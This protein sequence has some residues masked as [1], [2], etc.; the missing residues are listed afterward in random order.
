[1]VGETVSSRPPRI[2]AKDITVA[3]LT[4]ALS[5]ARQ[6]STTYY[7][8]LLAMPPGLQEAKV[9]FYLL[10]RGIDE[11]EDHP[12]LAA[13][14]KDTV[15]TEVACAL[16]TRNI[17]GRLDAAFAEHRDVLPDVS[18]RLAD[19]CAL[20]PPSIAPR[21][22]DAAIAMANRMAV[23]S[24]RGWRMRD[25]DDLDE[26]AFSVAGVVATLLGDMWAWHDGTQVDR[27]QMMSYARGCQAANILADLAVDRE[28]G[29]D[30]LPEGWTVADLATYVHTELSLADRWM[31]T[32]P[33]PGPARV[34]C[35]RAMEVAWAQ[36]H[37]AQ[38]FQQA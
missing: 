13:T 29:V 22:L 20:A 1:M 38:T 19:W 8:P 23:W 24:R 32:L 5:E 10:F 15:L 6:W 25:V 18:L 33:D 26:Y 9:S 4:A 11:I 2:Y 28:R 34:W 37:R 3:D 36:F 14:V 17:A 30:F 12:A 16:Q 7:R 27:G 31:A 35:S 21:I